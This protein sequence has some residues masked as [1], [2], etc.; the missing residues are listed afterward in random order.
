MSLTRYFVFVALLAFLAAC[1]GAGSSNHLG[2]GGMGDGG[3]GG[4]PDSDPPPPPPPCEPPTCEELELDGRSPCGISV[5]KNSCNV[6]V[7][8]DCSAAEGE[9]ACPGVLFCAE[10]EDGVNR[11]REPENNCAPLDEATACAGVSCGTASDGCGGQVQ[12]PS[13]CQSGDLCITGGCVTPTCTAKDCTNA[14]PEGTPVLCGVWGDGCDGTIDCNRPA[15]EGGCADGLVCKGTDGTCTEP[16]CTPMSASLACEGTCGLVSDGCESSIDCVAEGYTCPDGM[17]CGGGGTSGVCGM[18][19]CTPADPLVVCAG[20][21]GLVGDGCGTVLYNCSLPENGGVMCTGQEYCGGGNVLNECGAPECNPLTE[22]EAC[23]T[24]SYDCGAVSD[25]CG[26]TVSCGACDSGAG[27]IC[28]YGGAY[29]VCG[30]PS[31]QPIAVETACAGK[32]GQVSNGCTGYYECGA[33]NG[34]IT[35]TGGDWCGAEA[36]NTCG[37]APTCE[38]TTCAALGYTCGYA[39]D[40]CS[41]ILNCW[42]EGQSAC[43]NANEACIGNPATCV[44]GSGGGGCTGPLCDYVPSCSGQPQQTR[45]SG[46]VTTPDGELGVPNAIVYIPQD[47]SA[48]LPAITAGPSCDLCEDEDDVLGPVLAGAITDFRGEFTLE[49]NIPVGVPFNLVVKAG[50]WRRVIEVPA[51]ETTNCQ[52]ASV[53]NAYT[54]L[55]AHKTDGLAGTH[56]PLIAIA[57]GDADAME[58]VFYKMG[59]DP[60]EFTTYTGTGRIHLYRQNGARLESVG[61]RCDH[62]SRSQCRAPACQESQ[63]ACQSTPCRSSGTNCNW[64]ANGHPIASQLYDGNLSNG[65]FENYDLVVWDCEGGSRADYTGGGYANARSRMLSYVNSGGRFFASHWSYD[66]LRNNGT[67]A[68][69]ATW[70][71]TCCTDT[72]RAY[73][74]FGRPRANAS[75]IQTYARW[76]HNEG[77]GTVLFDGNGDPNFAYMQVTDP[78]D[79]ATSVNVGSDEWMFRTTNTTESTFPPFAPGSNTSVQQFSFNTPFNEPANACGRVAYTAFHVVTSGSG[80]TFPGNCGASATLNAQEKTLAYMLFDLAACISEGEP[81]Q[82]PECTPITWEQACVVGVC[83]T[84]SN[85]CGGII[86]CGNTCPQGQFCGVGGVCVDQ[87]CTP[88]TCASLGANCGEYV[89]GCGG[90]TGNCGDCAQG[91]VCGLNQVGVCGTPACTPLDCLAVGADCGL[92]GNGCGDVIDCGECD[93]GLACGGD[94]VPNVCGVGV[95]TPATCEDFGYNC[96]LA[97]DGCG[98]QISCGECGA[99]NTCGGG[100]EANVCGAP[101]CVPLTCETTGAEC[102][103]IG[104][105][106]GGAVNCLPCENGGVCGGAGPNLCGDPCIPID[107]TAADAECGAVADGCGNI[108]Q[109]GTCDDG[110]VCGAQEA[111]QCGTGTCTP[112]TCEAAGANCGFIGDGCGA[113]TFCGDCTVP[114]ET[115]GGG[116]QANVCGSGQGGCTPRTCEDVD[117]ECGALGNGCGGLLNCGSCPSHLQCGL[118]QPNQCGGI[119]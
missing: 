118:L 48:P 3:D 55:P 58:C 33:G 34:G 85:G 115:C 69:S 79:Q 81:P 109:C 84:L 111:N 31:C 12:C 70:S 100:G 54:T 8:V 46:R 103:W 16:E 36:P 64:N 37:G 62:G 87:T 102:G 6:S 4:D 44:A 47:P 74:S 19:E 68:N 43:P 76:L 91:Q 7:L 15:D 93:P 60:S 22:A 105:G 88:A 72:D 32:C 108:I 11:C 92:V 21:C 95:C 26:G 9:P 52:T 57:T 77:A 104:D 61:L 49:G 114:G 107:C 116:N 89:D 10:D 80:S 20:K 1:S 63:T 98:G 23:T 99:P 5:A 101:A 71:T 41:G 110:F 42:P 25:G 13:T 75:R 27:E 112:T 117:A 40:G 50:K 78:R 17:T 83:G 66:W 59:I 2:D 18:G 119:G 24:N 30:T 56:M 39:P 35:C 106:C 38:A 29:N 86:D 97:G 94:G 113:T 73:V 67:L 96:G 45:V 53:G 82:P 28:G 14:G 51:G 90:T 65:E